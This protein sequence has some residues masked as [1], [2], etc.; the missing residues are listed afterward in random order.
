[1]VG[2]SAKPWE[3][4]KPTQTAQATSDSRV[5]AVTSR[6]HPVLIWFALQC[7]KSKRCTVSR[8]YDHMPVSRG[9]L[10]AQY[11][12]LMALP[13]P[14][15]AMPWVALLGRQGGVPLCSSTPIPTPC[16]AK[17]AGPTNRAMP[18]SRRIRSGCRS[19]CCVACSAP[20]PGPK[21]AHETFNSRLAQGPQGNLRD[22]SGLCCS[23]ARQNNVLSVPAM[24]ICLCHGGICE[25]S[26]RCSCPLPPPPVLHAQGPVLLSVVLQNATGVRA[27][28]V[29]G[30]GSGGLG[31]VR[32]VLF[33]PGGGGTCIQADQGRVGGSMR[34]GPAPWSF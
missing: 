27:P 8:G 10:R 25:L 22:W 12:V 24:N 9:Y 23:A 14:A 30:T 33:P 19:V 13:T 15:T 16:A 29:C 3:G 32:R 31:H 34:A 5:R 20:D 7:S 18:S 21:A 28:F 17:T 6:Q 26:I 11:P 4:G 2:V 1:M